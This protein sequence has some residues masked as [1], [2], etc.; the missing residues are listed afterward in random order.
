ML[1]IGKGV[2]PLHGTMMQNSEDVSLHDLD[3]IDLCLSCYLLPRCWQL[4]PD[5]VRLGDALALEVG[6]EARFTTRTSS[7]RWTNCGMS[8]LLDP[9]TVPE[10]K[11][12]RITFFLLRPN[13]SPHDTGHGGNHEN[14]PDDHVKWSISAVAPTVHHPL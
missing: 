8:L 5:L 9:A 2:E 14:D 3:S 13:D 11:L 4:L 6:H 10:Q 7:P 1:L 12:L